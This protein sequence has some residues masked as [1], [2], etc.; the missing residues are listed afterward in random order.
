M[1][2][3][4]G[5]EDIDVQVLSPPSSWTTR[6]TINATT[7]TRYTYPLTTTEYNGGSPSIQFVDSGT[8]GPGASNLWVDWVAVRS[9]GAPPAGTTTFDV[10]RL[11][12]GSPGLGLPNLFEGFGLKGTL[13]VIATFGVIGAIFAIIVFVTL[14]R[15]RRQS[16]GPRVRT[17]NRP[18]RRSKPKKPKEPEE[19]EPVPEPTSQPEER[20]EPEEMTDLDNDWGS[21]PG[22]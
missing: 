5:D 9:A 3:Y 22:S 12:P 7:N 11:E 13:G 21:P 10:I 4:R 2:G 17:R 15:R 16:S 6:L 18:P 8:G 20:L 1:T 14:W 19:F